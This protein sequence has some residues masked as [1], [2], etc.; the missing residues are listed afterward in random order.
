MPEDT[1]ALSQPVAAPPPPK[2]RPWLTILALALSVGLFLGIN[3]EGAP[4]SIEAMN[5]WGWMSGDA[6][7]GGSYWALLSSVFLHA[8]VWHLVSNLCWLWLLGRL[9][10]PAIGWRAFGGF[11]LLAAFVSSAFQLALTGATGIGLSG[12]ICAL[13]GFMWMSRA[14]YPAFNKY[15]RPVTVALFIGSL[16]VCV[17]LTHFRILLFA[18]EAHI[19]GLVFG[20]LA[21]FAFATHYRRRTSL[22]L[23]SVMIAVS[24][25]FLFWVPWSI[26]WLS[27]KGY[28]AHIANQYRQ[29]IG[30][31][32]RIIALDPENGW[33]FYNRASAYHMAGDD[34]KAQADTVRA[35]ELGVVNPYE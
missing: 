17:I 10:E 4:G 14:R 2:P 19:I 22:T 11:F 33:A 23:V 31:Y 18:N 16:A 30:Y 5:R 34:A 26:P 6:I 21:A 9:L 15:V 8:E 13:F 12:V 1:D 25:L 20:M 24:A 28:H 32:S 3:A 29:A 7:W 27:A 35:I